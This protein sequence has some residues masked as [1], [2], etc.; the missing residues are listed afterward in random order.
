MSRS[1][2]G[3]LLHNYLKGL[4]GHLIRREGDVPMGVSKGAVL[5]RHDIHRFALLIT[6]LTEFFESLHPR[7]INM[8]ITVKRTDVEAENRNASFCFF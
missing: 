6:A 8:H 3:Q 1:N 2:V 4:R 5:L 7:Y